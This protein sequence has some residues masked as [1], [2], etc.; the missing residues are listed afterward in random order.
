MRFS[1]ISILISCFLLLSALFYHSFIGRKRSQILKNYSQRNKD[2]IFGHIGHSH[3]IPVNYFY[4]PAASIPTSAISY[5]EPIKND[6]KL[7]HDLNIEG[8]ISDAG[9]EYYDVTSPNYLF[10]YSENIVKHWQS[11][12]PHGIKPVYN[13]RHPQIFFNG[14]MN[15]P[16]NPIFK[17]RGFWT[18]SGHIYGVNGKNFKGLCRISL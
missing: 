6:P 10:D 1:V 7:F 15:D 4:F 11:T 18:D 5:H 2:Y 12:L 3:Y 16:Y 17:A 8:P 9:N 14:R 13:Y